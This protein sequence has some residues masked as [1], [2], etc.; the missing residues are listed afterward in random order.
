MRHASVAPSQYV[1]QDA[2]APQQAMRAVSVMPG[3]EYSQQPQPQ[4]PQQPQQQQQRAYVQAPQNVRYVDA[5][6]NEVFPSQ[7]RQVSEFR[8]Q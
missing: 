1:R 8:Y 3:L 7:V 5:N 2:P 6:G 4:Q